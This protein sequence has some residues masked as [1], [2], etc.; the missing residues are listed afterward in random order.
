MRIPTLTDSD[1]LDLLG[2]GDILPDKDGSF[3]RR[4]HKKVNR[5]RSLD[6]RLKQD[7]SC[8]FFCQPAVRNHESG[9]GSSLVDSEHSVQIYIHHCLR[10]LRKKGLI[11]KV[12]EYRMRRRDGVSFN[13]RTIEL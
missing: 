10:C 4:F 3:L 6:L 5:V 11:E 2:P 1:T 9:V 7:K 12:T 13:K 8:R